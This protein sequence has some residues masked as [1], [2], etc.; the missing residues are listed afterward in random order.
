MVQ[1]EVVSKKTGVVAW[2]ELHKTAKEAAS[3]RVN[4]EYAL[5][6]NGNDKFYFVRSFRTQCTN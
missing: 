6:Q 5:R 2:S 4:V 1:V 3:V